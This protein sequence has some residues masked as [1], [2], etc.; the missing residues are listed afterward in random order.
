MKK[1]IA[2]ILALIS[3]GAPAPVSAQN[4][5][6]IPPPCTIT[7]TTAPTSTLNNYSGN[8]TTSSAVLIPSAPQGVTRTGIFIQCL[9]ATC[10]LAINLSGGTASTSAAGNMVASGQYSGFNSAALGFTPQGAITAIA[11][12]TRA[13]TA[14]ACPR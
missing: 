7:A 4:V 5:T 10:T 12:G 9:A 1:F 2:I 3:F 14:Y 13:V 6:P 11:D 8:V